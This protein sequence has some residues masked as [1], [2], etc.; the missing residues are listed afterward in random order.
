MKAKVINIANM[1]GMVYVNNGKEAGRALDR[2]GKVKMWKTR[3][4]AEAY[5][6]REGMELV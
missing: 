4:G 6:K 5:A 1:Y 2:N 3:K